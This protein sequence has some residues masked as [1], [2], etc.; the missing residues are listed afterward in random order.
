ML[1]IF[2][3][4]A[5]SKKSHFILLRHKIVC[6]TQKTR[7]F[8]LYCWNHVCKVNEW[9]LVDCLHHEFRVST[10]WSRLLHREIYKVF[11]LRRAFNG[12]LGH[13]FFAIQNIYV[14]SNP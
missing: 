8:H 10:Q 6:K 13:F 14:N 2:P 11:Q 5:I 1:S 3:I 9:C 7:E 4:I 12:P